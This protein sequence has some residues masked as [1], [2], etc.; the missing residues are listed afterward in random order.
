MMNNISGKV[1]EEIINHEI[2]TIQNFGMNMW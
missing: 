1:I 2:A